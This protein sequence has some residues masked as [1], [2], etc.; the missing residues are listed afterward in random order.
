[1]QNYTEVNAGRVWWQSLARRAV[2]EPGG[3]PGWACS[4]L[5]QHPQD[6]LEKGAGIEHKAP[7]LEGKTQR[8]SA[9]FG[10]TWRPAPRH[11]TY[12][13]DCLAWLLT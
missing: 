9:K 7:G 10:A 6:S 8:R 12:R 4:P 11:T 3:G 1:M 13:E 5:A 2:L